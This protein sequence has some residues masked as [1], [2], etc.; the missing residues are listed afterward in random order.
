MASL[1]FMPVALRTVTHANDGGDVSA[2]SRRVQ[3]ED[4]ARPFV[5]GDHWTASVQV[6]PKSHVVIE[7]PKRTGRHDQERAAVAPFQLELGDRRLG[8]SWMV[9]R[10]SAVGAPRKMPA[11]P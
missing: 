4:D 10:I 9:A 3:P 11:G 6:L 5:P 2:S 8:I 1:C 7:P